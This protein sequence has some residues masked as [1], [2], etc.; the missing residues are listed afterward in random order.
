MVTVL[1]YIQNRL[2]STFF[3]D[4]NEFT[5]LLFKKVYRGSLHRYPPLGTLSPDGHLTTMLQCLHC[6]SGAV[7]SG[8]AGPE[9]LT[10]FGTLHSHLKNRETLQYPLHSSHE[11]ISN[12][13]DIGGVSTVTRHIAESRANWVV[14]KQYIG[15]FN[16]LESNNLNEV[17][18][19]VYMWGVNIRWYVLLFLT[20]IDIS[21]HKSA[22]SIYILT[23]ITS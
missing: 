21:N 19:S 9:N 22:N 15:N 1:L 16:L 4:G 7:R 6:D 5:T 18:A 13:K 8:S 3:D 20:M 11:I 2:K 23:N 17:C 14:H 12:L 10:A